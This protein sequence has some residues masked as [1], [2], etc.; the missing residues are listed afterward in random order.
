MLDGFE[1][2]ATLFTVGK[3]NRGIIRMDLDEAALLYRVVRSIRDARA[4]EIGRG[5][6][7]STLLLAVAGGKAGGVTSIQLDPSRDEELFLA[8][9]NGGVLDR[10]TLL[11][12]DSRIVPFDEPIDYAYIDGGH[13]YDVVWQPVAKVA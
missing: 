2:L 8:A 9:R 4:V 1:D 7:G 13:D 10:I 12:G 11:N 6:G 3:F 5:W